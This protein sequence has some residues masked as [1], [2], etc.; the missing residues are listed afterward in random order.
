MKYK[1]RCQIDRIEDKLDQLL[2]LNKKE[3]K[4]IRNMAF[5]L[6]SLQQAVA[7]E[8]SLDQ[9]AIALING[10]AGQLAQLI[11]NSGNTVDPAAVQAIVDQM[12]TNA[13]GLSAALVANTPV[14]PAVAKSNS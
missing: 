9:S 11:A 10:I 2:A 13:A 4:E 1:V 6:T 14:S 12:T 5:D 8:T 7:N 3:E